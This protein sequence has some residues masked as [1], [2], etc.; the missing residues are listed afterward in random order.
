M[1]RGE[2]PEGRLDDFADRMLFTMACHRAVRAGDALSEEQIA[3][4]LAEADAIEHAHTCPHGRPT[5]VL[6]PK[7]EL[8]NLFNRRGF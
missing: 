1:P 8:E 2:R 7:A 5:R 3:A 6:I 4:L